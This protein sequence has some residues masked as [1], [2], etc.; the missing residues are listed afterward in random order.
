MIPIRPSPPPLFGRERLELETIREFGRLKRSEFRRYLKLISGDS[1]D[2]VLLGRGRKKSVRSQILLH[3]EVERMYRPLA[4]AE[5][6]KGQEVI[7]YSFFLSSP[8]FDSF[9]L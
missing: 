7:L 4:F 1:C 2:E 6:R 8:I 3:E 9:P 5:Y